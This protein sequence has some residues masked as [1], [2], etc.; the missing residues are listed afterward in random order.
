MQK[1]LLIT[2]SDEM[3][4]L[5]GVRFV[6]RFFQHKAPLRLTLLYVAPTQAP[7]DWKADR[8]SGRAKVPE[9]T[10]ARGEKALDRSAEILME[11]GFSESQIQSKLVP[12]EMETVKE[13]VM[14]ARRGDYDAVVLGRRGYAA[15]V[16]VF[17]TSISTEVLRQP[18]PCPLWIC[19]NPG[20]ERERVLLC[21]DDS[22]ASV[23]IVDHVGFMV[24]DEP[25][26]ICLFHVITDRGRQTREI[27][28]TARSVLVENGV[29][30]DRI[31]WKIMVS[32][33]VSEAIMDECRIAP[34]SVVAMGHE[35]DG[36]TGLFG[37]LFS[38]SVCSGVLKRFENGALWISK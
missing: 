20:S 35:N 9:E 26:R 33:N 8:P 4:H 22:H 3:S 31:D 24:R 27:V 13:I 23:R 38:G 34:T 36:S 28:D 10:R 2:V 17:A 15:F 19:R 30:A 18:L 37:G 5:Y 29:A 32:Q 25:H 21:V 11:A 6:A 7:G 12:K 1:H 14:E 16:G